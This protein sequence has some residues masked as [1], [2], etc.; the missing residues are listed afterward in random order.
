MDITAKSFVKPFANVHGGEKF[1]LA[2]AH[3]VTVV[4]YHPNKNMITV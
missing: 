4:S 1:G 2:A 3:T